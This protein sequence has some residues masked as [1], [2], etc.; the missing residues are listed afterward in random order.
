MPTSFIYKRAPRAELELIP[1][2]SADSPMVSAFFPFLHML[3]QEGNGY[4]QVS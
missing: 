4:S 1:I 3:L 2:S